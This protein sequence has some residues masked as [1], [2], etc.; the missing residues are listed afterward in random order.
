MTIYE[1]AIQV[2]REAGRPLS[3]NE[4]HDLIVERKLYDF[5]ARNSMSVLRSAI[6]SRTENINNPS[7]SPVRYFRIIDEGKYIPLDSPIRTGKATKDEATNGNSGE[8]YD[9]YVGQDTDMTVGE[10]DIVAVPSDFNVMTLNQLVDN[11]WVRIPGFQRHFVWDLTRSSKLIESLI[12]GL[13]VPQLFL[14]EQNRDR[15]LLI[16]GQQRLMSIYYFRQQRFPRKERRAD[17]RRIFD[18]N[19]KIPDTVLHDDEYFQDFKLR[20][21]ETLPGQRN[22][23]MGLDYET[24]GHHRIR[25]DTRPIRCITIKQNAPSD[26]DSAMYE[27]FNRLNSGGVNLHPQEIRTSMYHSAFYDMLNEINAEQGWRTLLQ[28]PEPDLHMKDI[29]ILLRGFAMLMD[30]DEYSPSMVKFLNQ[31]SKRCETNENEK[32]RQLKSLFKSFLVA[33]S[34]LPERMFINKTNNRFNIALF[35]AVFTATCRNA[36]IN[37]SIVQNYLDAEKIEELRSDVTFTAAS[38]SATT[39][40]ENVMKRLRIASDILDPNRA[41]V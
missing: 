17:L 12:L 18:E 38:Q 7:S 25:L 10:Y 37:N 26:G 6:R 21:P 8:L 27:V 3:P 40:K 31:F 24:L 23:L 41:P 28:S 2:M 30:S 39:Q 33:A 15:N 35:E 19:G 5:K 13:P 36:Y 14:F 34:G 9:D 16:D 1:A 4:I 20:L 29:E 11:G 22:E 32:N